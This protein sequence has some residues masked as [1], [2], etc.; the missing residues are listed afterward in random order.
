M[1]NTHIHI[2]R[3]VDI[4]NQ[5]LPLTL[6]KILRT[7]IGY[8]MISWIFKH[9]WPFT[10]KDM[11][12]RYIRFVTIG[13]KASQKAIFDRC[14]AIYPPQTKF[15]VLSMDMAFMGAGEVPRSYEEQIRTLGE[16]KKTESQ[17]IPFIHVDPRRE[18]IF[19]LLKHSVEYYGFQGVKLYPPL[20][21]FPYD[22][23]LYPVY[24]YC[25]K[26]HLPIITHCSPYNP[27]RFKGSMNELKQLLQNAPS[28]ASIKGKSRKKLCSVFT[29]PGNY[30]QV[31]DDFPGLKLCFAHFGSEYFW[32]AYINDGVDASN[33]LVIIKEMLNKYEHVYAD[34]SFTLHKNAFF[35]LLKELLDSA[36]IRDKILFGSDYYMLAIEEQERKFLTDFRNILGEE[37]FKQIAIDNPGH[38]LG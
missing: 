30:N 3:D 14:K 34:V 25:E 23:R 9:L 21:Y 36:A 26:Y 29:H 2:F 1:Y 12:D 37:K 5:F 24:E 18:G 15:V 10:D 7:T 31:L 17:I 22:E 20:G 4:P 28:W 32:D 19:E 11:F 6:V 35:D 13:K 8:K 16:L 27:V 38:F 33:W